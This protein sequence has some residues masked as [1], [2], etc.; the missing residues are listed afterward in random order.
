MIYKIIM[1]YVDV[2]MP[3]NGFNCMNKYSYLFVENKF[4]VFVRY[5]SAL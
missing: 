5:I 4:T 1:H 3:I 2:V